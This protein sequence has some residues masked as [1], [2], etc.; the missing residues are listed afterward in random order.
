MHA[1]ATSRLD[2]CNSLYYGLPNRLIK[3]HQIVQNAAARLISLSRKH[4]HVTPL[5]KELH[6]L[7]V[8]YR[9]QFKI[10][11]STFKCINN[12]AH[13]YLQDLV[14]FYIPKRLLRSSS[15]NYLENSHTIYTWLWVQSVFG[16]ST[17]IMELSIKYH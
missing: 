5:L 11:F 13:V 7:P 16:S 12:T 2:F 10:L 9:I 1:F 15:K 8:E 3:K 14:R 17:N 6:W 4:D